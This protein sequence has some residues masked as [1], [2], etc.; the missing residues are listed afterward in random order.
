MKKL[1]PKKRKE[2]WD[3]FKDFQTIY[4]A[5]D[6]LGTP[7][8]RPVTLCVLDGK[9]WILT[10][11]KDVKVGQLAKNPRFEFCLTLPEGKN[12][13][14]LRISGKSKMVK[15]TKARAKVA[16]AAPYFSM[17]WKTPAD[18]GFTLLL[19]EATEVEYMVPGEMTSEKYKAGM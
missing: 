15:D 1:T 9:L 7:R 14:Y 17:F 6:D 18:P 4:L 3:R 10:G 13:G 8:V 12:S 5:T 11:T 19:L 2:I 16:K